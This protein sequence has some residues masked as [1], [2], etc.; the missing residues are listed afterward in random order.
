MARAP[1]D[2]D[3][4]YGEAIN[5]VG[6]T[7]DRWL[8]EMFKVFDASNISKTQKDLIQGLTV[9][10]MLYNSLMANEEI[11][12]VLAGIIRNVAT[13]HSYGNAL[14]WGKRAEVFDR[15]SKK[16]RE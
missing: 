14:D 8:K 7:V 16:P 13:K 2:A 10:T 11:I 3:K 5:I 15:F 9:E 1:D 12:A 4:N 6:P